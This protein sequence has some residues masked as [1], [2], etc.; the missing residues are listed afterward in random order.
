MHSI[1]NKKSSIKINNSPAPV[2]SKPTCQIQSKRDISTSAKLK[3][4]KS[5][6]P[7]IS[8]LNKRSVTASRQIITMS[9]ARL[10]VVANP[11]DYT[12]NPLTSKFKFTCPGHVYLQFDGRELEYL[13]KRSA[14][15]NANF[16]SVLNLV[17]NSGLRSQLDS[18]MIS[19]RP[20]VIGGGPVSRSAD[21]V[22]NNSE[23]T[24]VHVHIE[25]YLVDFEVKSRTAAMGNP[26]SDKTNPLPLSG[27]KGVPSGT[28]KIQLR[29]LNPQ[30]FD[31]LY[32]FTQKFAEKYPDYE[33]TG[34][35]HI[36]DVMSGEFKLNTGSN[37]VDFVVNALNA[38][39]GIDVWKGER[40]ECITPE[41]L[42][43]KRE[44]IDE[45]AANGIPAKVER[46]SATRECWEPYDPHMDSRLKKDVNNYAGAD[47]NFEKM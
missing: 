30:E 4:T 23:T 15:E 32:E 45:L 19:G 28:L 6:E 29:E 24:L 9:K 46:Y 1:Y 47:R 21:R 34:V 2:K 20:V 42:L 38:C 39:F 18:Q 41:L 11:T 31:A 3:K 22:I 12:H 36:R 5:A 17:I 44:L 16:N 14:I 10:I 26:F 25:D 7:G 13:K 35:K 8:E 40:P 27:N 33:T 37:C 43:K